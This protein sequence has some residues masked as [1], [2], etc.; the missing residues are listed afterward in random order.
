MERLGN[1]CGWDKMSVYAAGS[2]FERDVKRYFESK[3]YNVIRS[4][5]SKGPIDLFAWRVYETG[6]SVYLIQCKRYKNKQKVQKSEF[7]KLKSVPS[8]FDWRKR[9]FVKRNG[10]I[11]EYD[12]NGEF[13]GIHVV[14]LDGE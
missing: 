5:G 11:E 6:S 13:K 9:V 7:V 12:E 3:G 4:A 2:N 14:D 10:R 8:E 1:M